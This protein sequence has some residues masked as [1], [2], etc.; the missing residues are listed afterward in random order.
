MATDTGAVPDRGGNHVQIEYQQKRFMEVLLRSQLVSQMT[1]NSSKRQECIMIIFWNQRLLSMHNRG[2]H[3]SDAHANVRPEKEVQK[4]EVGSAFV[5]GHH[6]V[7]HSQ[8]STECV[9][10]TVLYV[11]QHMLLKRTNLL[12]ET[13]QIAL[14]SAI[15]KARQR[16]LT[17]MSSQ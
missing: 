4:L 9:P 7:Q 2:Q 16:F 13:A 5:V 6:L 15:C 1:T 12:E 8:W 14:Q 3:K 10:R 11:L 17:V